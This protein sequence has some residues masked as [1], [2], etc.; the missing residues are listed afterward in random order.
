MAEEARTVAYEVYDSMRRGLDASIL[1]HPL[2]YYY[3]YPFR[4]SR[5]INRP[6][7]EANHWM[8]DELRSV[9]QDT[10]GSKVPRTLDMLMMGRGNILTFVYGWSFF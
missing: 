5:C 1:L 10:R 6:R 3:D 8:R 9:L 2:Y 7:F 4:P